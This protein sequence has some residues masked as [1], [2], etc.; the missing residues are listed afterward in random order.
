MRLYKAT[1]LD[2]VTKYLRKNLKKINKYM[3]ILNLWYDK[4]NQEAV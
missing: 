4:N 1:L 3:V 2:K